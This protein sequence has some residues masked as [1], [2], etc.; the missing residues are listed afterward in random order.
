[1]SEP[2]VL[3]VHDYLIQR[4]GAE[5]V[6]DALL[7]IYPDA[8]LATSVISDDYR[9]HHDGRRITTTFLQ[10]VPGAEPAF[11]ALLPLYPAAFRRMDAAGVRP[12]HTSA[13]AAFAHHAA[14][15]AKAPVLVYCHTPPR[16]LWRPGQYF[17]DR[18]MARMVAEP[19]LARLRRL[20]R[21]AA[22]TPQQYTRQQPHH[23]RADPADLPPR[24]TV[25]YPPVAVDG[26][27]PTGSA[28]ISTSW[29][30]GC[31]TTSA[32][33]WR[34]RPAPGS[35]AADRGRRR[36][37]GSTAAR[38]RRPH[39]R[40]PRAQGDDV[41]TDLMERCRAFFFPGEED[42]GI[43]PV[44]AMAAGAPVIAFNRA[45]ATET[46]LDGETGLLFPEQTVDAVV[47][48]I[49]RLEAGTWPAERNRARPRTSA[50]SGSPTAFAATRTSCSASPRGLDDRSIGL[51]VG[52]HR[53]HIEQGCRRCP[54]DRQGHRHRPRRRPPRP[55]SSCS[56]TRSWR[57]RHW[58][59][60]AWACSRSPPW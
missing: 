24:C 23:R 25:V 53:R 37:V 5:R 52:E 14:L 54:A 55:T 43:S 56:A 7:D 31:W 10:R 4:G 34:W 44:E 32:S 41:V 27:A 15:A 21:E 3:I 9:R 48:A 45:G 30:R 38:G 60:P 11:R 17:G 12:D 49:E 51:R 50:P 18:R 6:V 26:S 33:T 58:A 13:A 35:A 39:G 19:V 8:M 59:S 46:V 16:F 36:P 22:R 20:D 28:T 42:F 57:C 1:M 29:S 40:V 47:Q 2:R